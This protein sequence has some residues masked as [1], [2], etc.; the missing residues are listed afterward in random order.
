MMVCVDGG[1][2]IGGVA[3]IPVPGDCSVL[4]VEG[5]RNVLS[6]EAIPIYTVRIPPSAAVAE[7]MATSILDSVSKK[8]P[9]S[10]PSLIKFQRTRQ[11]K[12]RRNA[13]MMMTII[14]RLQED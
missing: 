13:A 2:G 11:A 6:A 9:C 1:A 4:S 12:A 8:A 5:A 3:G 14:I 10:T 7:P